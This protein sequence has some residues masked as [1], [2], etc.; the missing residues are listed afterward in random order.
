MGKIK[1]M[2]LIEI[3]IELMNQGCTFTE[4]AKIVEDRFGI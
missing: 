3:V 4:A 2:E 1:M